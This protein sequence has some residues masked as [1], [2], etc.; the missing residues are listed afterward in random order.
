M[1]AAFTGDYTLN[2]I[3]VPMTRDLDDTFSVIDASEGLLTIAVHHKIT[4]GTHG[5]A[6]IFTSIFSEN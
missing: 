4:E 5:L 3:D 1:A 6:T 2:A